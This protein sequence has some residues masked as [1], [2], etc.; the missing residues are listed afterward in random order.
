MRVDLNNIIE[1][2]SY[3]LAYKYTPQEDRPWHNDN[4]KKQR[5]KQALE[6]ELFTTSTPSL[7]RIKTILNPIVEGGPDEE[8]EAVEARWTKAEKKY[9]Q[10]IK[11]WKQTIEILLDNFTISQ[12]LRF[13]QLQPAVEDDINDI[14]QCYDF[15]QLN[16][17]VH[18]RKNIENCP[19]EELGC[20]ATLLTEVQKSI[21][22][23]LINR[24][25]VLKTNFVA[26]D[27][28]HATPNKGSVCSVGIV[29]VENGEITDQYATLI[30]PPNNKYF[31]PNS[32][33]HGVFETDTINSPS[34]K[35]VWPEIKRRINNK[36]VIAHGANHTDRHCLEQAME[37][38]NIND[39]LNISWV[40]TQEICNAKLDLISK[41]CNI[42]L[43]HH[44]ALSDAI[45]CAKLYL[46]YLSNNLPLEKIY[47][48]KEKGRQYNIVELKE[49]HAPIQRELLFPEFESV[50]NKNNPFFKKKVVI[51]GVYEHW[52]NRDELAS[53]LKKMGADIDGSVGKYTNILCTGRECGPVKLKKMQELINAGKDAQILKEEEIIKLIQESGFSEQ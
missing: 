21:G 33:I 14:T 10:A 26:I 22:Q 15:L 23:I 6:F 40:D 45:A 35:D 2:S 4:K 52:P 31:Q 3:L 38:N 32:L 36:T 12:A 30:Q 16:H 9:F 19:D 13:I 27:F 43:D 41:V 8:F 46:L 28:E 42:Q 53:I 37:I 47:D 11:E 50:Q 49:N 18:K 24:R 48:Y 34:F 1:F 7:Q 51:T 5:I 29:T 25:T 17:Y 39:S 44:D 20:L